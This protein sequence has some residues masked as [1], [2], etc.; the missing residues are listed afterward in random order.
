MR[1]AL[2]I[3]L[4]LMLLLSA[5]IAGDTEFSCNVFLP[6]WPTTAGGPVTCS[7]KANGA[8]AGNLDGGGLFALTA[9]ND[10]WVANASGYSERCTFNEPLNGFASGT[11]SISGLSGTPSTATATGTFVWTRIGVNAI[12]TLPKAG[13]RIFFSNG[14][15]ASPGANGVA[16]A[17]FRPV[18]PLTGRTCSAPGP[19]TAQ[20]TG[21]AQF[22]I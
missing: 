5:C 3:P 17:V 20:V 22:A 11:Y 15:T 13:G 4:G 18:S 10:P 7:G 21:L 8:L 9:A 6:V 2:V 19:L 16:V 14:R 12:V 1:K